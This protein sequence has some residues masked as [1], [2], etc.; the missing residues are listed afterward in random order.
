VTVHAAN[1]IRIDRTVCDLPLY[2]RSG[3]PRTLAA[4][5]A[6]ITCD[7][8]AIRVVRAGQRLGLPV[9]NALEWTWDQIHRYQPK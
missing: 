2:D 6:D 1:W 5:P 4:C 9:K 8:C 7:I 3:D